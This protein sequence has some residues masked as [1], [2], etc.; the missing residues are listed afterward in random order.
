[1]SEKISYHNLNGRLVTTGEAVIPVFDVGLLRGYGI[2]DFFPI[3][4]GVIVFQEDYFNRFFQSAEAMG[5]EVPVDQHDLAS[6]IN[7]LTVANKISDGYIKLVLTGG[8]SSDGY[9]PAANNLYILQ[10]LLVHYP[11]HYYQDGIR[12]ILQRFERDHPTIKSLNYAN[13]LRYREVLKKTD[14]MDILYHDGRKVYETSRANFFMVDSE[15]ILHTSTD[16]MLQGVT[17]KHIIRCALDLG[18]KVMESDLPLEAL[19]QAREAFITSTTKDLLPVQ[20]INDYK[21]ADG[22]SMPVTARLR[23]AFVKYVED[24]LISTKK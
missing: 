22:A 24:H 11:S 12:L 3:R 21:I 18:I 7:D 9:T 8:T 1:M 19:C 23:K 20:Q 17:R 16:I 14:A 4:R 13:A 15:G 10:H 2:F 6:R 5:L